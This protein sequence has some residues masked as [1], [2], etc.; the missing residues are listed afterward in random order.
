M[1]SVFDQ[2]LNTANL[3]LLD[4]FVFADWRIPDERI[5]LVHQSAN[6]KISVQPNFSIHDHETGM[7][8][9]SKKN[10]NWPENAPMM[11][12]RRS[13]NIKK[14]TQLVRENSTPNDR[15]TTAFIHIYL[16]Q[17]FKTNINIAREAIFDDLETN[18][19]CQNNE[20][21]TTGVSKQNGCLNDEDVLQAS[22]RRHSYRKGSFLKD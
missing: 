11:H 6:S 1:Q 18:V 4:I 16:Y 2:S 12:L 19:A 8:H 21:S 13:A 7:I 17:L 14:A 15:F 22:R 5:K 20:K 3:V 9:S 10:K